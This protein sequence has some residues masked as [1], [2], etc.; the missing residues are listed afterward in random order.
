MI[1]LTVQQS[2][3]RRSFIAWNR[4]LT[5]TEYHMPGDAVS[6]FIS[7]IQQIVLKVGMRVCKRVHDNESCIGLHVYKITH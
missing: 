3:K 5:Q 6:P 4:A 1:M 2:L 7:T